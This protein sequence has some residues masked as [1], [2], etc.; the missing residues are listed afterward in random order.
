MAT[1]SWTM[2]AAFVA[3]ASRLSRACSMSFDGKRTT[4]DQTSDP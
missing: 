3:D 2:I 4:D 1:A